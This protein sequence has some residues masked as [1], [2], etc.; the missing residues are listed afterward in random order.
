MGV[1]GLVRQW[2]GRGRRLA[3]R[4]RCRLGRPGPPSV[5]LPEAVAPP[6]IDTLSSLDE[7]DQKLREVDQAFLVSDDAMRAVFRGFKMATPTDLLTDP[8]SAEYAERQFELYR[9]IAA[10]SE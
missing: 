2:G 7:L 1:D 4:V 3:R 5:H 9:V 8:A 10:R 6:D